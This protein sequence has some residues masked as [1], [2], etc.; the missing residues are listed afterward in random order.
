MKRIAFIL[1]LLLACV[2]WFFANQSCQLHAGSIDPNYKP[3]SRSPKQS[4]V[5][6]FSGAPMAVIPPSSNTV[7][8]S[9]IWSPSQN[10]SGYVLGMGTRSGV[11][12][13]NVSSAVTNSTMTLE[14]PDGVMR[15]FFAVK[16]T[17]A[18]GESAWSRE[19]AFPPWPADRAWLAWKTG[20]VDQSANLKVWSLFT[21]SG[22]PALI[23]FTEPKRFYRG[24]G[25]T[26]E[27]FNPKNP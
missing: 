24:A 20:R 14:W 7:T 19:V 18:T 23:M 1:F 9:A 16:A 15:L 11:Y 3:A 5:S 26:I 25:L 10:A 22:S 21:N 2:L 17:N 13:T 4:E 8:L 6:K 12:S 27:P